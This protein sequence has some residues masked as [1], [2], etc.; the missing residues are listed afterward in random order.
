MT[1][2]ETCTAHPTGQPTITRPT[3]TNHTRHG[4]RCCAPANSLLNLVYLDLPIRFP[5]TRPAFHPFWANLGSALHFS[6]LLRPTATPSMQFVATA[7]GCQRQILMDGALC[8]SM[9]NVPPVQVTGHPL[10]HWPWAGENAYKGGAYCVRGA[11]KPT[12]LRAIQNCESRA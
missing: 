6:I 2:S 11:T 4:A 7:A 9:S 5:H 10:S 12:L 3:S 1:R 8:E